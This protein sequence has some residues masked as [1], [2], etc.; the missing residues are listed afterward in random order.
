MIGYCSSP[1]SQ[2]ETWLNEDMQTA[3]R[4]LS[5]LGFLSLVEVLARR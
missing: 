1:A 2:E 4:E 3:Y 5:A